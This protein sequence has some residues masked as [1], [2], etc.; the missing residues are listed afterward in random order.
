MQPT[1]Y[2]TITAIGL[3]GSSRT[4]FPAL[5]Q[6]V[7]SLP[8]VKPMGFKGTIDSLGVVTLKWEANKDKDILGYRIFRGNNRNEEYS[9]I[10]VAPYLTTVFLDSVG[11]KNLNSKV[12][13]TLVAVDQRFN[14]SESSDILEI[15]KLDFIKPT[16]A[17][18]NSYQIKDGKVIMEWTNSSSEDVIKHEIYRRERSNP[19]WE[20]LYTIENK[21]SSVSNKQGAVQIESPP[22]GTWTDDK[23]VEGNEYSYTIVAVDGSGLKSDQAPALTLVI[24][25]TTLPGAIKGL[26]SFIDKENNYIELYWTMYKETNVAEIAIYKGEKD[27][28]MTLFR[29]VLPTVNRIVDVQVKPNNEY[30]YLLRAVFKDGR[31]SE[32][33]TLNVKY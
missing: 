24:P 28:P 8:P 23:V 10:T 4:S 30:S 7:D 19:N 3:N 32:I 27:K 29:N 13:Y 2:L 20:L 5:V 14:M 16:Q 31:V 6:P 22:T 1:N 15:K 21:R 9:Q 17:I 12:Y 18:F 26:S 11:V 33:A 25:K